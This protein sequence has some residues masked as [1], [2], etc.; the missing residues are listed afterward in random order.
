[1]RCNSKYWYVWIFHIVF[2][3]WW[4]KPA[5]RIVVLN[6][7]APQKSSTPIY[8]CIYMFNVHT[9]ESLCVATTR[10]FNISF[11]SCGI[12]S[13]GSDV[14]ETELER[15]VSM[16][17]CKNQ[18]VY[19]ISSI[20]FYFTSSFLSLYAFN[21]KSCEKFVCR[22]IPSFC[23]KHQ[24]ISWVLRCRTINGSLCEGEGREMESL[25]A[26]NNRK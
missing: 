21:S 10:K 5:Q 15:A 11:Y 25:R 22:F 13:H 4:W 26:T 2:E 23:V 19:V 7:G 12:I 8:L 17:P 16:T 1:M 14:G 6:C 3:I 18:K 9:Y 24:S 20:L